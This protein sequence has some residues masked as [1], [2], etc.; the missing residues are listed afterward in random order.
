MRF[1]IFAIFLSI[2][3][4]FIISLS[5][6]NN[7]RSI[8][9]ENITGDYNSNEI[10]GIFNGQEVFSKQTSLINPVITKTK[11][12]GEITGPKKIEID[13][14]NQKLYA[15][16]GETKIYDFLISSG[17]WGKTP[18]GT[19]HIW[20]KYRYV[21]MSGGNK[22]IHT[23]YYLPNVPFVM[24][25]SNE[26]TPASLGFGI[27]GTYWHSNFGHPMSHGCINMK[28]EEAELLY[29]WADEDNEI[30][31]YGVAPNE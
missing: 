27:H 17:K 8:N 2:L 21:T 6:S 25:F 9:P 20:G 1:K 19:F 13:L 15:Y 22:A 30:I 28:T 10:Q 29:N 11:V 5:L 4:V 23:Y 16:M 14:T 31:I 24:F 3:A 26:A 12:L 18:T 7:Q